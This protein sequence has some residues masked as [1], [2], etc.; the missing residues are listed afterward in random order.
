MKGKFTM[1]RNF[2]LKNLFEAMNEKREISLEKFEDIF[3]EIN[4]SEYEEIISIMAENHITLT[5]IADDEKISV[6]R[7]MGSVEKLV[8]LTNEELCSLI[9]DGN[10]PSKNA[11][12]SKNYNFVHKMA[13]K[14]MRIFFNCSLDNED[15]EMVGAMALLKAA[16]RFDY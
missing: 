8:N 9:Q 1:N 6:S 7:Y 3:P 4:E 15:L 11:L 2:I 5:E 14:Y 16:Q 10:E 13:A 12:I